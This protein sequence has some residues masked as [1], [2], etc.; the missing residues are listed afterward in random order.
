MYLQVDG[1]EGVDWLTATKRR[2][3]LLLE[4]SK[5]KS[6]R[7]MEEGTTLAES[8]RYWEAIK[9]WNEAIEIDPGSAPLHEMKSQ[10]GSQTSDWLHS[11]SFLAENEATR[12]ILIKQ[13]SH[14]SEPV[15]LYQ[16]FDPLCMNGYV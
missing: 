12:L 1:E 2:R 3:Q 14:G 6:K 16:S 5:A 10:V 13:L 8:G 4:D 9:H 7:L 15:Y 11:Q